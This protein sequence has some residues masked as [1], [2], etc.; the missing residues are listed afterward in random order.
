MSAVRR[1]SALSVLILPVLLISI[2]MSVL[3]IAVPAISAD[4]EPSSTQ[5]L[6]TI[7]IYSFLLAGLLV[8]MG[9]LGDRIGRKRLL[10]IGAPP[11]GA[12]SML[13]AFASSPEMLIAARA[14]LG[15][16]GATLMPSTL[17]LIRTIFSDRRERQAAIA[18]WGAAFSGGASIGP[19][20]GGVLLEHY[21]WGAAFLIN[22]PV[23]V[24]F[25][26]A[27]VPLLPESRDPNPGPFDPVSALLSIGGLLPLVYALKTAVK[28]PD[29]TAAAAFVLGATL[30]VAFAQRQRT[31]AHPMLDLG[32][33]ARG[34]FSAAVSTNVIVVFT[35]MGVLFFFPQYLML[36][37]GMGAAEAGMWLLPLA[38]AT[39]LGSFLSP[40]FAR[41]VQVRAVI[42]TGLVLITAGLVTSTQLSEG[43]PLSVFVT[44]SVL[45]GLGSG[46]AETL[47]NDV[48]L[49][50]A[51][52]ERAGAASA[53]SETG[54]EFGGAMGIALLGTLGMAVYARGI[55]SFQGL[56]GPALDAARQTLGAAHE[57]AATLPAPLGRQL[58]EA[59]S[60]AFAAGLDVVATVA[61]IGIVA[62]VF[63]AWRGLGAHAVDAE[64]ITEPALRNPVERAKVGL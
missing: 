56:D 50:V 24:I 47:T 2:D 52:P 49:T 54:Y 34:G 14:L 48:I 59:A 43:S 10:L 16:G 58:H 25:L 23:M 30:L 21:W 51:P 5:L 57:V 15:I 3:G 22:V 44:G 55:S 6:W 8:L 18:V 1:W 53:I 4:L 31:L 28:N 64:P 17:G 60:H 38:G 7:D 11:F 20:V 19:V 41:F 63:V 36:V 45:I 37:L 27:A 35:L 9:S 39:V 62:A 61:S 40:V 46:L 32:L 13:A 42:V 33:F 12:A 26:L 29:W